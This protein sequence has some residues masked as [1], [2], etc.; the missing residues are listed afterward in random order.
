MPHIGRANPAR[1]TRYG[2][3]ARPPAGNEKRKPVHVAGGRRTAASGGVP[4]ARGR[5]VMGISAS[6][7]APTRSPGPVLRRQGNHR[8]RDGR[9][10]K[11]IA[12]DVGLRL[13]QRRCF[14]PQ[15]AAR[16]PQT[17]LLLC[18]LQYSDSWVAL[19]CRARPSSTR[20]C[21][22]H[23]RRAAPVSVRPACQPHDQG[24]ARRSSLWG[25]LPA[26]G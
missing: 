23:P 1:P 10:T 7:I 26:R 6:D 13:E 2:R 18:C 16:P 15:P 25:P 8:E 24:R 19:A 17:W 11:A 4:R 22:A 9:R 5:L 20:E 21:R 3:R 12:G 14:C